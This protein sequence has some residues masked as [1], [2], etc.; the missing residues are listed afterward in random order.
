MPTH[1]PRQELNYAF[2]R[3][4]N[5]SSGYFIS[6]LVEDVYISTHG[7]GIP[8]TLENMFYPIENTKEAYRAKTIEIEKEKAH[9]EF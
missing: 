7:R 2:Y 4:N 3:I 6:N 8:E 1:N 9:D 5:L